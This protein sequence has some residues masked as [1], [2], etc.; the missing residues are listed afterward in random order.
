M[1]AF[2]APRIIGGGQIQQPHLVDTVGDVAQSLKDDIRWDQEFRES[3]KRYDHTAAERAQER[4]LLNKWRLQYHRDEAF[5]AYESA[6]PTREVNGQTEEIPF[7]EWY[8]D[9]YPDIQSDFSKVQMSQDY[10]AWRDAYVNPNPLSIFSQVVNP[11][12]GAIENIYGGGRR[13]ANSA[14]GSLAALISK[15]K[16]DEKQGGDWPYGYNADGSPKAGYPQDDKE[17]HMQWENEMSKWISKQD[18]PDNMQRGSYVPGNKTGDTNPAMLEDGE[19]VLN[20]NAVE[21]LGKGFLD[22]INHEKFPRF[23]QGGFNRPGVVGGRAKIHDDIVLEETP[24]EVLGDTVQMV[25]GAM[26]GAPGGSP[27]GG[28]GSSVDLSSLLSGFDASSLQGSGMDMGDYA[29]LVYDRQSQWDPNWDDDD[30]WQEGGYIK[31]K[32]YQQGG[33][34][35]NLKNPYDYMDSVSPQAWRRYQNSLRTEWEKDASDQA[36]RDI[37]EKRFFDEEIKDDFDFPLWQLPSA[38]LV[39]GIRNLGNL[40]MPG[41]P[42]PT[43]GDFRAQNRRQEKEVDQYT[44]VKYPADM[45]TTLE[46]RRRW[47]DMYGSGTTIGL[48][49]AT[50]ETLKDNLRLMK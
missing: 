26:M 20:R 8:K 27:G 18:D 14:I 49:S 19:Y 43:M 7:D 39:G 47:Q 33:Y 48:G 50:N 16:S 38:Y 32:G 22:Y 2:N 11:F 24:M 35:P 3:Q 15:D 6:P 10:A 5:R 28:G 23:Q 21:K 29:E 40:M 17:A 12:T 36:G 1:T 13:L 42:F 31:P 45:E 25:A 46:D 34:A 37:E 44:P 9:E 41:R 30:D 4:N